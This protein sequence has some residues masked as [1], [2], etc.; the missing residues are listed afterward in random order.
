MGSLTLIFTICGMFLHLLL[1]VDRAGRSSLG[2]A[3][4]VSRLAR[5]FRQDVRA[6]SSARVAGQGDEAAS[7]FELTRADGSSV[8][9]RNEHGRLTRTESAG[10]KVRRREGYEMPGLRPPAFAL[11]GRRARL[12][13]SRLG[14]V[15]G[16]GAGRPAYQVE[17][18]LDK[19]GELARAGGGEDTR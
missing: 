3:S 13:L 12:T 10:G 6:A 2:E 15:Q 5:Q 9:Y 4:T 11:D 1:R 16:G 17:A 8:A 7:A 19:D 14:D 18:R